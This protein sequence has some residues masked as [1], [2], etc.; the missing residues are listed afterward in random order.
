MRMEDLCEVNKV[1]KEENRSFVYSA[2]RRPGQ[3]EP[4]LGQFTNLPPERKWISVYTC[5]HIV[6]I[7]E[8]IFN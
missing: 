1:N 3:R 6:Y 7:L 4:R 2:L 8:A 5:T